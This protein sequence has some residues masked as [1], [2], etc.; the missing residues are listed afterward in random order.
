MEVLVFIPD[1]ELKCLA[2]QVFSL[3]V[4]NASLESFFSTCK[5]FVGLNS[6]SLDT[7]TLEQIAIIPSNYEI[8]EENIINPICLKYNA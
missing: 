4:S 2:L 7:E 8:L 3:L 1:S 6:N 5:S